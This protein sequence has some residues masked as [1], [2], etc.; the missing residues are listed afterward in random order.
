[1]FWQWRMLQATADEK[2]MDVFER[3]L[4]NGVNSACRCAAT[5]I[6]TA[7]HSN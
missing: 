3:A 5:F 6:A 2:Y 1:M 4:Y 7:I